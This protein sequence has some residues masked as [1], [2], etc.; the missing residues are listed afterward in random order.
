M[1]AKIPRGSKH[2]GYQY[3]KPSRLYPLPIA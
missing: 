2:K 1:G 3:L